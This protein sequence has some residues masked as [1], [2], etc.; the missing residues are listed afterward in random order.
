MTWLRRLVADSRTLNPQNRQCAPLEASK[1]YRSNVMCLTLDVM[2]LRCWSWASRGPV[3]GL[4]A[5]EGAHSDRSA[6]LREAVPI[7]VIQK[8]RDVA[9]INAL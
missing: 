2:R 5:A 1:N 9:T 7:D 3:G 8:T 6:Q 4:G